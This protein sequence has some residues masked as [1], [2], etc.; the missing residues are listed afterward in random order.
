[1]MPSGQVVEEGKRHVTP[2]DGAASIR[3]PIGDAASRGLLLS[4][5]LAALDDSGQV[6][7]LARS[8]LSAE[9]VDQLRR[10]SAADA[11]RLAASD[12]GISIIVNG[13]ALRQRLAGMQRDRTDRELL[14][15]F[16]RHGA[17]ARL[18][19]RLFAM[20]EAEVRHARRMVA[21]NLSTGGRPPSPEDHQRLAILDAWAR[22]RTTTSTERE[23]YWTL[24]RQFPELPIASLE[25]II[26]SAL[27]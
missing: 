15:H 20:T 21:P 4:R 7:T 13:E 27:S 9:L 6:P 1:M 12:C 11:L 24:S 10:M 5:V 18:V 26:A 16:L 23:R 17:S 22:L 19:A 8:G 25:R 2:E 3:I 14:E